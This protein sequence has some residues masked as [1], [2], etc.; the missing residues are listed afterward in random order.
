MSRFKS[1]SFFVILSFALALIS[2][3]SFAG[4]TEIPLIKQGGVYTLPVRINEVITLN[5]ILDSG[6]SEVVIPVDVAM[7]LIRAGTIS[8]RDFL[9]GKSF[10]LAD[11]SVMKSERF[12]IRVLELGGYKIFNVPGAIGSATSSLL[13][14]QNLLEKFDNW[15]LDNRRHMLIFG[16]PGETGM[17]QAPYDEQAAVNG[18]AIEFWEARERGDYPRIYQLCA[19][20]F[21]Q[22]VSETSFLSKKAQNLYVGH[23]IEWTEV[24]G[25]HARVKVEVS[26]RPDDPHLTKIEPSK[27]TV[28]QQ[29]IKVNNQ[30]YLDIKGQD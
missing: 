4:N 24:V 10:S 2:C 17:R 1:F 16:H 8:E 9:P 12:V 15:T 13:L 19:P 29:W 14:G 11:G 22:K 6:A 5:F 27:Q 30:W 25:D 26:F 7:T 3:I 28:F 18:R 20:A 21:R 23:R